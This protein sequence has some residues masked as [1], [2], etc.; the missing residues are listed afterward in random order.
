MS[1]K[2]KPVKPSASQG[3]SSKASPVPG[4]GHVKFSSSASG[5]P[6]GTKPTEPT[7]AA[8]GKKGKEKATTTQ[9]PP[10]QEDDQMEGVV[11]DAPAP[12]TSTSSPSQTTSGERSA[13]QVVQQ[14]VMAKGIQGALVEGFAVSATVPAGMPLDTA[15]FANALRKRL[16][17]KNPRSVRGLTN[18]DPRSP[19]EITVLFNSAKER[20]M[21][22]KG[23]LLIGNN[24]YNLTFKNKFD[25]VRRLGKCFILRETPPM[26]TVGNMKE[27]L[28]SY[29]EVIKAAPM[30]IQGLPT[31]DLWEVTVHFA[32]NAKQNLPEKVKM[33]G[34]NATTIPRDGCSA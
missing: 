6:V 30:T 19:R 23:S 27:L 34:K 11:E 13:A 5:S 15:K 3:E 33:L 21:L 20:E 32:G 16:G 9:P 25:P 17:G 10:T 22:L 26:L 2:D 8:K 31:D 28:N 29:G 12:T 18:I 24:N 14:G 7:K 4:P 1:K